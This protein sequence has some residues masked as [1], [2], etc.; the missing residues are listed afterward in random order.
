MTT[1]NDT[2][3][4]EIDYNNPSSELLQI[5]EQ[6]EGYDAEK[7]EVAT[8][9]KEF[10]K[11]VKGSGYDTKIIGKIVKLRARNPDDVANEEALTE[12]YL[13]EIGME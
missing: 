12:T 11:D 10:R 4:K 1:E 5:I 9:F 3:S 2:E 6:W 7:K 13:R 8:R